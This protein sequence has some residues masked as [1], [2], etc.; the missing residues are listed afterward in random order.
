M[1]T[2]TGGI[3]LSPPLKM[4]KEKLMIEQDEILTFS[5]TMVFIPL[6]QHIGAPVEPIVSVG[7]YVKQG[8]VIAESDAFV[9]AKIHASVSGKIVDMV[10]WPNQN[11]EEGKTIIIEND[12][13]YQNDFLS[14]P[15]TGNLL[16]T[17]PSST[18]SVKAASPAKAV[19]RF[20]PMSNSV[21]MKPKKSIL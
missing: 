7:D 6:A 9:S 10:D 18:K 1:R 17:K 16:L 14:A 2:F 20:P 8:Q 11:N 19:Q 12:Y 4:L 15:S 21:L 3:S 5:P 13:A